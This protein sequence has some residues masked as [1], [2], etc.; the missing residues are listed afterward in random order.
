MMES[1]ANCPMPKQ[2][3]CISV[4]MPV[5]NEGTFIDR[6]LQSLQA[7]HTPDFDLEILVIDGMSHDDTCRKVA[8]LARSDSR[9]KLL[10]NPSRHTPAALNIGL[11]EAAA[12]YVCIMGAHA[13]Y[14]RDYIAVCLHELLTRGAVGCSGK[15]VTAPANS[16]LQA[17][18]VAWV[19]RHPF[20]SSPRSVRTQP[21]GYADT[22]PF[23]VMR[24]EALLAI[25]G[26]N[27][28][29]LRNQ[30]NDMNQRLRAHGHR[31]YVTGKTTCRYYSRPDIKSFLKY[32][33]FNGLGNALS[34]RE[35]PASMGLRHL[36]P[37]GF[38]VLLLV[39]LALALGS[40]AVPGSPH[41]IPVF[42]LGVILS[43]HLLM[44][45]LAGIETAWRERTAA[46]LWLAPL[47]LAFH[48]AYGLGTLQGL[49]CSPRPAG[50]IRVKVVPESSDDPV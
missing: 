23:P 19:S 34:L 21:E 35:S 13:A 42:A 46:A 30:D 6:A 47:I 26:Y 33:F 36:A 25:G 5:L 3:A 24:K 18:L 41:A 29:L 22:V 31:L 2:H 28:K 16:C 10:R 38:V 9:I 12:E 43:G 40:F 37:L 44:G 20:A 14:D 1:E 7:Q 48:C 4:I 50:P 27:E 32:A 15:V 11:R 8:A 39:L 17:R 45:T 49:L